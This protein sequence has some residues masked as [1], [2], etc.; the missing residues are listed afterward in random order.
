M[1]FFLASHS[2]AASAPAPTFWHAA[3]TLHGHELECELSTLLSGRADL[4][5]AADYGRGC[6]RWRRRPSG[7]IEGSM[8]LYLYTLAAAPSDPTDLDVLCVQTSPNELR[9]L[10]FEP[11]GERPQVGARFLSLS[12]RTA[13]HRPPLRTRPPTRPA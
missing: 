2:A 1:F 12:L 13:A 7:V 10:L 6:G 9:G 11:R 4:L 3:A 8:Q 5:P